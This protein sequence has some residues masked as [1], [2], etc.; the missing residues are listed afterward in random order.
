MVLLLS[1][2]F[3]LITFGVTGITRQITIFLI[4]TSAIKTS[5]TNLWDC[6][7][8]LGEKTR[9]VG[10]LSNTSL[11]LSIGIS[12]NLSEQI[13]TNRCFLNTQAFLLSSILFLTNIK[14][15]IVFNIQAL[16][17]L[18]LFMKLKKEILYCLL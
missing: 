14:P 13:M 9:M 1:P 18:N 7:C 10:S 8:Q 4:S 11:L 5:S 3:S 2:S 17:L 16:M 15:T 12:L 6:R